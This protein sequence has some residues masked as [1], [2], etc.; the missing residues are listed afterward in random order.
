MDNK[1]SKNEI[2]EIVN[3]FTKL[4]NEDNIL[5]I[6]EDVFSKLTLEHGVLLNEYFKQTRLF[7][8]PT[9][10]VRFFEWLKVNDEPVW[11]DLWNMDSADKGM[12][13]VSL[14]FLPLILERDGRGMPICDLETV[15]NYFFSVKHF[16][17][18]EAQLFLES[19]R[20]R[21]MNRDDLT[22]AQ[23]LALEISVGDIDIWHFAYKHNVELK[24]AKDAVA[25]L[26]ADNTLIH[27]KEAEHLAPFI[28]F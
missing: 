23:L 4:V 16:P 22:T 20:E 3:F 19:I 1:L 12:Y 8:L 21:F 5:V 11:N 27:L 13:C 14:A 10:E 25:E 9:S 7:K 2:D 24:K 28:Q 18:R 17:D 15:D 6:P 26:V